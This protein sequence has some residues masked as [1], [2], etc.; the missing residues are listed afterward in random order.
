MA[1]AAP[2]R[3]AAFIWLL[4]LPTAITRTPRPD[5][6]RANFNPIGPQPMTTAVSPA[7]TPVSSMPRKTQASGS[8]SA[9]STNER[10]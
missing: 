1:A 5:K 6:I 8:R 7:C 9:A 10:C 4:R 2:T 3:S